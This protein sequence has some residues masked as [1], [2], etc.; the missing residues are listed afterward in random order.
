MDYNIV[1]SETKCVGTEGKVGAMVESEG[2]RLTLNSR[3]ERSWTCVTGEMGHV[4]NERGTHD[5]LTTNDK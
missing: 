2:Q 1:G 4:T 5:T 3:S